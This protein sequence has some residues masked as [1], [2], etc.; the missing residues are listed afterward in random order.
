GTTRAGGLAQHT[1]R[2]GVGLRRLCAIA[3][4]DRVGTRSGGV[5]IVEDTA[6]GG[7]AGTGGDR[8]GTQCK[9]SGVR[10]LGR[11]SKCRAEFAARRSILA[12]SGAVVSSSSGQR[13]ESRA[14]EAGRLG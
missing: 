5:L 9:G 2:G 12:D 8:I 6:D 14:V 13:A 1:D 11:V 4:G 7:A 10:R 3:D